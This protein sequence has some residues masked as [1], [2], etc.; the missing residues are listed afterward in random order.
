MREFRTPERNEESTN[1]RTA[2]CSRDSW[3]HSE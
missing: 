3:L 1:A 2:P